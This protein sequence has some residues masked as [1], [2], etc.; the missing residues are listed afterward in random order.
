MEHGSGA[1]MGQGQGCSMW[2]RSSGT[3][4]L[5][6]G[7]KSR[8]PR[9]EQALGCQDSGRHSNLGNL[10]P[11]LSRRLGFHGGHI[12]EPRRLIQR[13]IPGTPSLSRGPQMAEGQ[14]GALGGAEVEAGVGGQP[15]QGEHWGMPGSLTR[16]LSALQP[17]RQQGVA[18]CAGNL[19]ASSP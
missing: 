5:G 17:T 6:G 7:V 16:G 4:A 1:L 2:L 11:T 9:S 15:G 10:G 8:C 12:W 19:I 14:L 3:R 13:L 18:A